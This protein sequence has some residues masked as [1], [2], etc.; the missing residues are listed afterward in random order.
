MVNAGRVLGECGRGRTLDAA[1]SDPFE[2]NRQALNA[3]IAP[4][5]HIAPDKIVRHGISLH[6][7]DP[8]SQKDL[9][10]YVGK[11]SALNPHGV[12]VP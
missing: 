6:S 11:I 7:V 5:D 12:Q 1:R 9:P 4:L 10:G 8:G 2:E 3:V